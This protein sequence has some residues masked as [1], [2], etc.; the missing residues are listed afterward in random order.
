MHVFGMHIIALQLYVSYLR[1]V[2]EYVENDVLFMTE[3]N[4][5]LLLTDIMN[6]NTILDIRQNSKN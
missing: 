1:E 4:C 6:I 5:P 2:N 3:Y